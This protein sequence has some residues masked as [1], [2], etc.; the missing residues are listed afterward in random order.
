M[1][2]FTGK[3]GFIRNMFSQVPSTY[4]LVNH[5]LTFGMDIL[6][7]RR[8][9]KIAAAESGGLRWIDM[10]T[11]TGETA[12][13]LKQRAAKDTLIFGADFSL[14]MLKQAVKK[15]GAK[16]IRFTV[17]DIKALPFPD[18]SFDLITISFATRNLAIVENSLKRSISEFY[19]ILKPGG[20][21]INLETSQPS[22]KII[23]ILFHVYVKLFVKL[24]G[25]SIS[26]AETPY[27]YL[28][29]SMTLFYSAEEL[30]G[31]FK[32]AG[33]DVVTFRRLFFGAAAIHHS[34]KNA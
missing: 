7:R 28:A 30:A 22:C 33:F 18:E 26:G 15:E 29:K 34:R 16:H 13:Y 32:N 11:G 27:D 31:I 24:L 5:I 3:S 17:A 8:A 21:F 14:P 12:I 1:E 10:C 4:E 23:R 25:G 2:K 9:A 19:R 6:W 20:H